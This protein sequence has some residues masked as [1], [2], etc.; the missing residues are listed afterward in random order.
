MGNRTRSGRRRRASGGGGGSASGSKRPRWVAEEELEEEEEEAAGPV[1]GEDEELC[2][3]CKDG[4]D[5]RLCDYRSCHKAYHPGCVGKDVD[6]L[7]SDEEFICEWHTCFICEGRSRYYCFCC[8]RH[9]FCQG[10]VAQAE[11]VSV[12]RKTKGFCIDCLRMVIMIEKSVDVDSD[13]VITCMT[14]VKFPSF[15][16]C[17][18]IYCPFFYYCWSSPF[19][20]MEMS[21]NIMYWK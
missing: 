1:K 15:P 9:T 5:L 12:L 16:Y 13:G 7:K 3:V 21:D 17:H 19:C 18:A 14:S 10:C 6:F 8:P 4:G 11:F 20:H 2:F